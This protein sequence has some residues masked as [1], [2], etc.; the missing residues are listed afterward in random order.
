M[1]SSSNAEQTRSRPLLGTFVT[2]R[3]AGAHVDVLSNGIDAAFAA[4]ARIHASMSFHDTHSELTAV[5]RD[6]HRHPVRVS[7]DLFAVLSLARH[8]YEASEGVFDVAVGGELVRWKYLPRLR[9][10]RANGRLDAMEL[11]RDRSVRFRTPLLIDLGGIA[12]GYAVDRAIDALRNA[13]VTRGVVNAGGDLRIFGEQAEIVHVRHPQ[14]PGVYLP[15]AELRDAAVATSAPYFSRRTFRGRD[16]TPIVDP[17]ACAACTT[18]RSVS[19]L[20]STCVIADALTKV[21][22]LRGHRALPV[23]KQFGASALML[24][25]DGAV[26][27]G[28]VAHVA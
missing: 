19:V 1:P 12:K 20:A 16:V 11:S 15:I 24:N 22:A 28:G 10:T 2:I 14:A 13:G 18:S 9:R 3:A 27:I 7:A 26:T 8:V 17:A 6:A 25:A 21:V 5:N 4:I 23:L